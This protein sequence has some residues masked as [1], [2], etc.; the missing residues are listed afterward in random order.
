[1]SRVEIEWL[2]HVGVIAGWCSTCIYFIVLLPQI[3]QNFKRKNMVGLDIHW[4]LAN[5]TASFCNVFFVFD[6]DLPLFEKVSG[7]YV[8]IMEFIIIFQ[9]W[10]YIP[11]TS[12]E[13]V[14]LDK[15]KYKLMFAFFLWCI[16]AIMIFCIDQKLVEYYQ[17]L[18]LQG[19]LEYSTLQWFAVFLWSFETLL[20]VRLNNELS[21]CDGQAL[22]S[23]FLIFIER[24]MNCVSNFGIAQMPLQHHILVFFGASTS[25][26]NFLQVSWMLLKKKKENSES[27]FIKFCLHFCSIICFLNFLIL[28]IFLFL[29]EKIL[30]TIISTIVLW[31][32]VIIALLPCWKKKINEQEDKVELE[33]I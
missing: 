14:S 4:A 28:P 19:I 20:Q 18:F 31:I 2:E 24:C 9:F 23:V 25:F 30:T 26:V 21:D 12:D 5:F 16:I 29:R 7:I 15:T 17:I 6:L 13:I 3:C 11:K 1:M 10:W 22:G 32:T 27:K 8:P 33:K